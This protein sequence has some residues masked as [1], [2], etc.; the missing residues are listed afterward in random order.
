MR[1]RLTTPDE[2]TWVNMRASLRDLKRRCKSQERTIARMLADN[3][4][5]AMEA[6]IQRLELRIIDVEAR[7]EECESEVLQLRRERA[8]VA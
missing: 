4:L 5:A 1:K 6:E 2:Q 7:W 8:R 3:P